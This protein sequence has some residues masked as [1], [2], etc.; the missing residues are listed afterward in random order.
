MSAYSVLACQR[1]P[2]VCELT[3]LTTSVAKHL[4]RFG[5]W[6]L[7]AMFFAL[8]FHIS[9]IEKYIEENHSETNLSVYCEHAYERRAAVSAR[10]SEVAGQS[11]W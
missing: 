3:Q 9:N 7:R 8:L 5:A 4:P 2:F 1:W 10:T 11:R 6:F